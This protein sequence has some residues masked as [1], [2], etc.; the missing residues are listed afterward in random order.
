MTHAHLFAGLTVA[1]FVITGCCSQA[2]ACPYPRRL[3][4]G[5]RRGFDGQT[6]DLGPQGEATD[7]R[8]T[9]SP[10]QTRSGRHHGLPEQRITIET[11][12]RTRK[13]IRAS[14]RI[15]GRLTGKAE[16]LERVKGSNPRIQLGSQKILTCFER[17]F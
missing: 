13:I 15:M 14:L 1:V 6:Q 3:Q 10:D 17:L 12:P 9:C 7:G 11:D 16:G 4:F 5:S 8:H 2:Q